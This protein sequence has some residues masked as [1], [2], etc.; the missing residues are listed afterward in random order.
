MA[1]LHTIFSPERAT[2]LLDL[3]NTG[4]GSIDS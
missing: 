2:F 3:N 4:K 1:E